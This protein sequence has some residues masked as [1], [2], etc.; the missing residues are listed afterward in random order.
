MEMEA[1]H[2]FGRQRDGQVL[3][4][5]TAGECKT[6][7]EIRQHLLPLAIRSNLPTEPLWV[8]LQH[9]RSE[10]QAHSNKDQLRGQLI[11]DLKQVL[12]RLYPDRD[13][14]Q[15]RG[16][17]RS[18]RRRAI[19]LMSGLLLLFLVLAV[20]AVG[21][22]WV[23][24]QQQLSAE[25]RALAAQAEQV[26]ARDRAAALGLAI[27]AWQTAHTPESGV[28][29]ADAFPQLLFKLEGHTHPVIHAAFSSNGQRIVTASNDC[30]ARVWN[31]ANGQLVA[32]LEGNPSTDPG[33]FHAAF[34]PDGQR[35]VT[36]G[37]DGTAWVWNAAD[38]QLLA[39]L[40]G[41]IG[42]LN[43]AAF[44][45]DGR[46]IVTAGVDSYSAGVERS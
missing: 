25:S 4:V 46:R 2:W 27:R 13:W 19:G 42:Q 17:E 28:A 29:V 34:S 7:E 20:F 14:G 26:L 18:Q 33:V 41:H 9:R 6:W 21:S 40:E 31:A 39:K 23:A 45:P 12:L 32:K 10:I 35:I 43:D 37:R 38:G 24:R 8:P 22:A 44:S 16:E 15:L 1:R 30:T 36:A 3:I 5:V 11:E